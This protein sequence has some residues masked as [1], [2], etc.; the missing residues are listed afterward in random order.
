VGAGHTSGYNDI[1][2]SQAH[3][4]LV[5]AREI[6]LQ[7]LHVLKQFQDIDLISYGDLQR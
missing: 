3:T 1:D 4:R 5:A 6:E 2:L 7:A